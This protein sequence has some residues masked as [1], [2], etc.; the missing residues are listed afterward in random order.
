MLDRNMTLPTSGLRSWAGVA[1]G[2][3]IAYSPSYLPRLLRRAGVEL[4][5]QG[6]PSVIVWNW[7]AVGVLLAFVLV[8]EGRG[9]ASLA[10]KRPSAK[11]IE[12]AVLFWGIATA[13]SGVVGVLMPQPPSDGLDTLLQV[14][15]PLLVA[16]IF[17]TATTEE[18]LYRAYPIERL[19][20]MTG[21]LWLGVAVSF[22]L[23]VLPHIAF[24]G[25]F[26]LV[27]NGVSVV[28][29]YVLFV[30]RR[31]LWACMTMH[32]L[33]NAMVLLPASGLVG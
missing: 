17:T 15:L 31:N 10:L 21:R 24:F 9:L 3:A 8:V 27:S 12:W 30:W 14:P 7:L 1:A 32:L 28:L 22:G 20:Q 19:Q 13:T 2:L 25:P 4:G 18:V 29:L 23:F 6:P 33:G 26:W 5:L 16:L 11:D